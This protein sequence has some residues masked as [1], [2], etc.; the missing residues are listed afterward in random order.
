MLAQLRESSDQAGAG[1]K[2]LLIAGDGSFCNRTVLAGLPAR[3]ELIARTRKD[4]QL[5]FRAPEGSRRVLRP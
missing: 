3:V 4:A 5:C 2:T 1:G